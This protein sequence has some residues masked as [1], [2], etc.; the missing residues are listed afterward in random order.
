[1]LI[2]HERHL[3]TVDMREGKPGVADRRK[4]IDEWTR[5]RDHFIGGM[6][7]ASRPGDV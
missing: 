2:A 6:M 3:M 5:E 1:L 7:E 4:R